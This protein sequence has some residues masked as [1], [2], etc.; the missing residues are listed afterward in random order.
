MS[1]KVAA[2]LTSQSESAFDMNL[3][4]LQLVKKP[5][6]LSKWSL[7]SSI[8]CC[9]FQMGLSA[10]VLYGRNKVPNISNT[11]GERRFECVTCGSRFRWNG[12]L[13]RHLRTHTGE[14]PYKCSHCDMTFTQSCSLLRHKR[15][16]HSGPCTVAGID[17]NRV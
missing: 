12:A 7:T 17:G 2:V 16:K 13:N 5:K 6:E 1:F 8:N 14:R 3:R 11:Q 4:I 9:V 15:S 10:E